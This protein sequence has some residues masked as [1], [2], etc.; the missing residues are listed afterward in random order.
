MIVNKISEQFD[1]LEFYL[2]GTGNFREEIATIL[3]YKGNRSPFSKPVHYKE[4]KQFI[5]DKYK[6][7]VVDG[8]EAD[9]AIGIRATKEDAEN[10]CIVTIDKDLD[11]I[12]G[13]HYNFVKDIR[14][15]LNGT[16]AARSFYKQVL[17]GDRVDNIPGI[18]G[19]GP[20]HAERIIGPL[21]NERAMWQACRF[22]WHECYPDGYEGRSATAVCL[23]VAKLLWISR[24]GAYDQEVL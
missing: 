11:M 18:H 17:M 3:P 7:A 2:S 1:S 19:I 9:D 15:T 8:M 5:V 6:A 13:H 10:V 23:E 22:K 4:I 21:S 20:K 14:Y 24:T 12:P 16:E